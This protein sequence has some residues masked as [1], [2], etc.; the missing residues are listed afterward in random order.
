MSNQDTPV[1]GRVCSSRALSVSII[2]PH[3]NRLIF[4]RP[5]CMLAGYADVGVA[6]RPYDRI[7]AMRADASHA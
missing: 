1:A 4:A 7:G 2:R 6:A 5:L 3:G